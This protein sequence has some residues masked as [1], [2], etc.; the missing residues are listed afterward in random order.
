ML[1][2]LQT[3]PTNNKYCLV[4]SAY[5]MPPSAC[6]TCNHFPLCEAVKG[7]GKQVR[8]TYKAGW[9]HCTRHFLCFYSV[10]VPHNYRIIQQLRTGNI[11]T[12]TGHR[13]MKALIAAL[14]LATVFVTA[15]SEVR[16]I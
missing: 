13:K 2:N 6:V 1:R 12:D 4:F 14:A 3:V 10:A 15:K 7:E 16:T 11:A 8:K 5:V 9:N